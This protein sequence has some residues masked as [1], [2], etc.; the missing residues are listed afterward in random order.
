MSPAFDVPA[1]VDRLTRVR[2]ARARI[3]AH[4]DSADAHA[5]LAW[6]LMCA[7]RALRGRHADEATAAARAALRLAPD[8]VRAH[9]TAGR[10]ALARGRNTEAVAAFRRGLALDPMEPALHNDLGL[11]L[12]GLG[13]RREAVHAFGT[14]SQIDPD[15]SRARDNARRVVAA[16][17]G[18]GFIVGLSVVRAVGRP[19]YEALEDT[20]VLVAVWT[21]I[22][23]I[24]VGRTLQLR[25]RSRALGLPRA[26][27]EVMRRL[28]REDGET[29][30]GF[31]WFGWVG[32]AGF[33]LLGLVVALAVTRG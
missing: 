22:I 17:V 32:V 5:D 13:L 12:Q 14:A 9:H 31:G 33:V 15:D 27:R 3:A 28:E 7:Y 16:K 20:P 30:W 6:A 24:G 21:A 4:P 19:V 18:F 29:S 26:D 8:S 11:A 23:A 2:E 25:V 10:V 1:E